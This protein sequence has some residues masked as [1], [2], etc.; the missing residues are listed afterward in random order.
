MA[1]ASSIRTVLAAVREAGVRALLMGG[2]AC[3][4]YGAAEFSH[5]TDIAVVA[6]AENLARLVGALRALRAS[7]TAVPPFTADVLARGHA[8]HF[9][10]AAADDTRLHVMARMRN[11]APVAECWERRTTSRLAGVGEIEVLGLA[12]LVACK[13]TRRNKDWPMVQRL[14]DV[15]L[16]DFAGAPTEERLRFWLRELRTPTLLSDAVA[17][18][19]AL[20]AQVAAER[21]AVAAALTGADDPEASAVAI[22][23]ALA[24]EEA[25]ER[26][27]DEVY[28]RP[29]LAEQ[30][31][32][33]AAFRRGE[34]SLGWP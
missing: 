10:C 23:A 5:D 25:R 28:W 34:L 16:A 14:V 30:A 32:M 11:V 27:A 7:V 13:K 18:A 29:L 24:D 4:L 9:R 6:D 26:A 22:G 17:L 20:A 12:D 19:P 2:Q 1:D 8:V 33:R 21:P 15:H 31:E 3:I